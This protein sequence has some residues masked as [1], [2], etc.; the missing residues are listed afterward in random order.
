MQKFVAAYVATA[1][2]FLAMDATWLTFM[3]PR[4]YRPVLGPLMADK[5]DGGAAVAFYAIYIGG[6]IAFAVRPALI[7]GQAR[8]ALLSGALMGLVAYATYDLTNQATLRLWSLKITIA[9]LAWGVTVS[10]VASACGFFAALAL[11]R[12]GR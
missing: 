3:G 7:N 6:L 1:V 4:L 8:T 2:A 11:G 9:D 5:V 12:S 10:A